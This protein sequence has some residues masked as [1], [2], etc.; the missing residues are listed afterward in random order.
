MTIV[1]YIRESGVGTTAEIMRFAKEDREG[2]ETMKR[3][4]REQ[5][6]NLGVVIEVAA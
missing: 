2:F 3:W 6:E 5:A 4:A 1:Q